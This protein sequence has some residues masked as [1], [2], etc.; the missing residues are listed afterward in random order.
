MLVPDGALLTLL[1]LL[2]GSNQLF[3]SPDLP[4]PTG[5]LLVP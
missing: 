3:P 1:S 2:T 5:E 4:A